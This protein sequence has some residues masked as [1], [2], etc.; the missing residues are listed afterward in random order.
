MPKGV[1]QLRANAFQRAGET[2]AAYAKYAEGQETITTQLYING[3]AKAVASIYDDRQSTR[4]YNND[5]QVADNTYV[6]C[7]MSAASTYF[8]NGLY[9]SYVNAE[10][11]TTTLRVGIRCT[12]SNTYYWSIFDHFRL[13]FF[14]QNREPVGIHS[15][16]NGQGTM[17][18]GQGTMDNGEWFDLSGRK[19]PHSSLKKGFYLLRQDDG[20]SRKVYIK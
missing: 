14:G 4:L 5:I 2:Q 1:Y 11:E 3:T 15:I 10:S 12:K 20:Q 16:E 17:D 13:Y 18:N 9:D 7:V 19:I 8:A 6:P